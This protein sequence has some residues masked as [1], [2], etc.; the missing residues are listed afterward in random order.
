MVHALQEAWRILIPRGI[1]IDLRPICVDVSL[2]IS[3]SNGWKSAGLVDRGPERPNDIASDRA[4]R[5]V[6]HDGLF[7]WI[8]RE[9]FNFNYYWN[10][11]DEL[12]TDVEGPWKEDLILS[13]ENWKLARRLFKNG[14]GPNRIRT[15]IRMK[16]AKY[17]KR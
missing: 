15:P 5:I 6:V 12:K 11:L 13:M 4:I 3:T 16:I 9:Y 8:N 1:L 2:D 10:D 14:S 7:V 17:R